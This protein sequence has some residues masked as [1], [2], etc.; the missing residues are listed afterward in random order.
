VS[1]GSEEMHV[2]EDT[3]VVCVGNKEAGR[4]LIMPDARGVFLDRSKITFR[5]RTP[6][7]T[8]LDNDQDFLS[9]K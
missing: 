7:R 4:P 1:P 9:R 5:N 6:E 3:D 2:R 8:I